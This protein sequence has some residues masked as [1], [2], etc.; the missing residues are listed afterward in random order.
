MPVELAALESGQVPVEFP[1][2]LEAPEEQN[3]EIIA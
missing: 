3:A 2:L 1:V